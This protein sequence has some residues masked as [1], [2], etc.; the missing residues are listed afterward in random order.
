MRFTFSGARTVTGNDLNYF[1]GHVVVAMLV[2][3]EK[4]EWRQNKMKRTLFDN[5]DIDTYLDIAKES[6]EYNGI[7]DASEEEVWQYA[8]DL[9]RE[10]FTNTMGE[11]KSFF[12][13]KTVMF[14]G[15]VG[16]WCGN[17]TG[18]DVGDFDDL[19]EQ[20]T[21][22]CE[23]FDIYDDNGALYIRCSHHDGTNLFQ[24]LTLT[25]KGIRTFEDWQDYAGKYADCNDGDI[26]KILLNRKLS[27]VPHV[28]K[29]VYG[30]TA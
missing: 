21:K 18:F 10:D 2:G 6:I 17:H 9:E 16:R 12:E 8:G 4:I 27:H 7:N 3:S 5:Y 20:Y 14:T 11:L 30:F 1:R 29:K 25:N 19:F 26:H 28:A 22:D 13:D 23:Y 24:V 15:A